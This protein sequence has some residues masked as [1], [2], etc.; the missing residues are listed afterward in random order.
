MARTEG[1]RSLYK[2]LAPT[3][4]GIAPYAAMNFACYDVLKK[5]YYKRQR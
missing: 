4:V 2:G 3:L 1:M 5:T